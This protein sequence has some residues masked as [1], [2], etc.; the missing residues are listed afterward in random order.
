MADRP[1]H[2]PILDDA[3]L[4]QAQRQRLEHRRNVGPRRVSVREVIRSRGARTRYRDWV[5]VGTVVIVS[6][7]RR[8]ATEQRGT[9]ALSL[10]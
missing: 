10:S 4:D 9:I 6:T 7:F 2:G 1:V 5:H 3:S 8:T